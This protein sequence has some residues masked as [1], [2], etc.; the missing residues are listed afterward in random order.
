M[1]S[2]DF[3]EMAAPRLSHEEISQLALKH[4]IHIMN[5]TGQSQRVHLSQ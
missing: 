3:M 5:H 2:Q 1:Y 4:H